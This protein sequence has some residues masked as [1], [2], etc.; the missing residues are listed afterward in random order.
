MASLTWSAVQPGHDNYLLPALLVCLVLFALYRWSLSTDIPYIKGIPEIPGAAPIFGHLLKLGEDHASVCEKW[1][2][3]YGHS[4]FQIKLGNTRAVVVNSFDDARRML[5]GH[6]NAVIDRPTLYT[7]HG[8][9]SSTQGFTI[10][11]SPWDASCKNKRKAAG[12]AL[13]RPAMRGYHDMFDL[14]S[15]CIMRDLFSDSKNGA[16]EVSVRPYIQRFALNTTLTLCYG[17]RMDN[18]YDDMLREILHV[19]SAIS[20]LR[21]ASENYQDYVPILRYFPNNEKNRRSKELRDRRDKYLNFLLNKVRDMIQR[22]TD[23]PCI[24]AA[25]LKDQETKLTGVE[26]S[27]ICLSLVSGGFETIPGTLTSCIGSLATAEGQI[28][29]DL[30]YADIQRYY[31]TTSDVWANSFLEEKV[32]Y[33][34]AI[35]KEAARYYTVSAMSLP[36]KTVTDIEWDGAKIPAKTMILINAQAANHETGHWGPDGHVFNPERWLDTPSEKGVPEELPAQGIQHYSFGAGSRACSGQFI[37]SRLLYTALIRI[38]SCYKIVASE[39]EPPN[40]D[41]VD[42]N[43]FKSALVAI[44]RDFKVKLVPRDGV[45]IAKVL[46][47]AEARTRGYYVE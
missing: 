46:G 15:Y 10:G 47:E 12:T 42:Y 36:R 29:Q 44:P 7:F 14:E 3:Q 18:V 28:F 26:V 20:L 5:V 25:I 39:S 33:V 6:Q 16:L 45:D 24:S 30:A 41:Y 2:K 37:A 40:T 34:N 31:G 11:S 27:S 21:S 1:F 32:P 38:L 43:Q 9:I 4:V 17:I 22:G 13:G 8:V 23:K 35:I 19:G